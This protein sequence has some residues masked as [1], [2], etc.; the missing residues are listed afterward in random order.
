MTTPPSR[1]IDE[2][3]RALDDRRCEALA[4]TE[5]RSMDL[6]RAAVEATIAAGTTKAR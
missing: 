3:I 1:R 2:R 6:V 5:P 4:L